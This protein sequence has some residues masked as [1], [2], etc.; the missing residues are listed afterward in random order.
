MSRN[1]DFWG[2]LALYRILLKLYPE[3]IR[4]RFGD[5]MAEEL[6]LSLCEAYRA[7]GFRGVCGEWLH[8][9]LDLAT[10]LTPAARA[11]RIAAQSHHSLRLPAVSTMET[12]LLDIRHAVRAL[13]LRP[14][15]TLAATLY[16]ALGIGANT[17]MFSV[18]DAALLRPLPYA[19]ADSI[20][21]VRLAFRHPDGRAPVHEEWSYPYYEAFDAAT[22]DIF[23]ATAALHPTFVA[24]GAP[25]GPRRVAAELVS[26]EYFDILGLQPIAGR[27]FEPGDDA[28]EGAGDAIVVSQ[29]TAES[30]FGGAGEALGQSLVVGGGSRTI[31]GVAPAGASGVTGEVQMWLPFSL[32]PVLVQPNYLESRGYFWHH[33][34]AK[35]GAKTPE[36]TLADRMA[37]LRP[38]LDEVYTEDAVI[39]PHVVPLRDAM[40]DPDSRSPLGFLQATALF[41][42]AI[43]CTNVAVL[44]LA[45]AV[46]RS[47]EVATRIAIGAGRSRILRQLVAEACMLGSL[48]A[49]TGSALAIG[50][51]ALLLPAIPEVT[52]GWTAYGLVAGA[53]ALD[54]RIFAFALALGLLSGLIF[55]I[56]PLF[57]TL[58]T[59]PRAVL[60]GTTGDTLGGFK[61]ASIRS[62]LPAVQVA[63]AV[64]LLGGALLMLRTLD[65]KRS[66][67]PGFDDTNV[68]VARVQLE[69]AR[70]PDGTDEFFLPLL[71]RLRAAS[72]T[73]SA[74]VASSLAHRGIPYRT[75]MAIEGVDA[76]AEDFEA[77]RRV[78]LHFVERDFFRT[79][80]LRLLSGRTFGPDDV[81][82]APDVAV[83]NRTLAEELFADG[84]PIGQRV[85][86]GLGRGGREWFEIVGV[87]DDAHFAGVDGVI[88]PEAYVAYRQ[89]TPGAVFVYVRTT[90]DPSSFVPSLRSA[91][92][93]IDPDAVLYDVQTLEEAGASNRSETRSLAALL[94]GF[95]GLA[96]ILASGGLY[97]TM[98][99]AVAARR[100]EL[101]IR[102]S[103]GA[104]PGALIGDV[105]A[106]GVRLTLA[107][108]A[109]GYLSSLWLTQFVESRLWGVTPSDPVT[110]IATLA[111]FLIVGVAASLLPALRA[112]A[113]D[114]VVVLRGE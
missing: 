40:I 74:A 9:V 41:V 79:I 104:T 87:V 66:A 39:T 108:V 65:A 96:L 70:Y 67:D 102:K 91:V 19:E 97:G 25:D 111:V 49:I 95:A 107:G 94:S 2:S 33:V 8:L 47:R 55:S 38:V 18:V 77:R 54:A 3:D 7:R 28:S 84:D 72:V 101:G 92:A 26:D 71:E 81:S 37:A 13:R 20:A 11:G 56:A 23:D 36:E 1:P 53:P 46:D 57:R 93:G 50:L 85:A 76:S 75:N 109:V 21:K 64:L 82:G 42:L 90:S 14:G 106:R 98:M 110:T 114:P 113:A 105:L 24:V 30:W 12:L 100:R 29:G 35:L 51:R 43:A 88:E 103:L 69:D 34:I 31:V 6:R 99:F 89:S 58:E 62:A 48:G 52:S 32:V 16:L 60:Q 112:S 22:A 61:L 68:L 73:E 17:A 4:R 10:T 86:F 5:D 27:F 44:M 80:R 45:R 59:S 63:F 78:R 15:L 83:V